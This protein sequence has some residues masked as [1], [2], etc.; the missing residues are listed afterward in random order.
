MFK[1]ERKAIM[2]KIEKEV[3]ECDNVATNH[4]Y[5]AYSTNL[6]FDKKKGHEQEY[7][8]L[9]ARIEGLYWAHKQLADYPPL[10]KRILNAIK[11]AF[12]DGLI[13]FENLI[14]DIRHMNLHYLDFV[15][16]L[17]MLLALFADTDSD[18]WLFLKIYNVAW[19]A[20]LIAYLL[21]F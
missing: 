17:N 11:G 2:A 15:P 16:F 6:P 9:V 13:W 18:K 4:F 1:T 8:M 14:D 20:G 5:S 21:I 12:D 7:K 3:K 19:I 10:H